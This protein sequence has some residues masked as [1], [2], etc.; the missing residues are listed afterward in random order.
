MTRE[1]NG[2]SIAARLSEP[3]LALWMLHDSRAEEAREILRGAVAYWEPR[4]SETDPWLRELRTMLAASEVASALDDSDTPDETSVHALRV[5]HVRN[6]LEGRVKGP[7][8]VLVEQ[9]LR[10]VDTARHDSE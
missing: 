1:G 9:T 4:T 2:T 3:S 5:A 10:R 6:T 8:P 7:L